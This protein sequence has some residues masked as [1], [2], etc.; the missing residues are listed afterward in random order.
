LHQK[1]KILFYKIIDLKMLSLKRWLVLLFFILSTLGFAQNQQ[2]YYVLFSA[3]FA[4]IAPFSIGGHAFITWRTEDSAQQKID[5]F[6]YGFF[7]KKG[8]GIFKSVEGHLIEGYTKNSNRER[9]VRRFIIEV[10]SVQFAE[11]LTEM[12]KW[13]T[14]PYNLFNNNC[15]GFMN[16]IAQKLGLTGVSTKACIFP[17]KPSRYIRKLKKKNKGRIIKNAY[18]EK[19]RLKMLRKVQV[20]QEEEDDDEDKN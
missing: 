7:P 1:V 18:L 11:S 10:D 6:T 9:F 4:T 16:D 5:Q 17:M 2:H 12:E 15:V 8:M 19:I 14:Q 13:K 3:R 20:E